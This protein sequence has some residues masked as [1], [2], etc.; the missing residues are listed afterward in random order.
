MLSISFCDLISECHFDDLGITLKMEAPVDRSKIRVVQ[1]DVDAD[2]VISVT[3]HNSYASAW[4]EWDSICK[5]ST[6]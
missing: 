3:I 5:A 6:I 2:A 1:R 4:S